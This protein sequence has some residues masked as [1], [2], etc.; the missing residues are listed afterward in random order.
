MT[1]LLGATLEPATR[2]SR[3]KEADRGLRDVAVDVAFA[4]ALAMLAVVALGPTFGG[5]AY[6]VI[7]AV[8]AVAGTGAALV[9]RRFL[10]NPI[11]AVPVAVVVFL[12][13]SGPALP[14]RSIAGIVPTPGSLQDLIRGLVHAWV[15]ALT[16]APPI[17]VHYGLG[18]IPY[19]GGFLGAVGGVSIAT[20]TK[21]TIAP[22]LPALLVL[23]LHIAIGTRDPQSLLLQGG[24]GA[25]LALGWG[26]VRSNRPRRDPAGVVYWPRIAQGVVML[27]AL[28]GL[29]VTLGP[30]APGFDA[31]QR[32]ILRDDVEPPFDPR[33]YPSP[34]VG[35]RRYLGD[36]GKKDVVFTVNGL[37]K[38]ASLRLATM[39]TYDGTVWAVGGP[40]SASSGRF[41][42]IGTNVVPVPSGTPGV[43]DVD[44]DGYQGVWVPTVGLT[45]STSFEGPRADALADSYRFNEVTRDGA[46][47]AIL[48]KGDRYHVDV[49]LQ[50][51]FQ[52]G[53]DR[54]AV[55][56]KPRDG[57]E[58]AALPA[59]PDEIPAG[60]KE[61]AIQLVQ[62][63][64]SD[65]DKAAQIE[66][67]FKK[68]FY[69][70]G[71]ANVE[72]YK[73]SAPGHSLLRMRRFLD[74]TK[75]LPQ[76]D[77]EQYAS[78]MALVARLNN[79]PARVVMG[80][81]L[82]DS[83]LWHTG[84]LDL[85]GEDADAW[86]EI[87]FEDVGWVRFDPTPPRNNFPKPQQ[88][89]TLVPRDLD[90]Q[91]EPE[92]DY[93]S[94]PDIDTKERAGADDKDT[95]DPRV[96]QG[97]GGIP[98]FVVAALTYVGAP[99]VGLAALAGAVVLAKSQRRKRR[100]TRGSPV[101]RAVG[102]WR[103]ALDTFRDHRIDVGAGPTRLQVAGTVPVEP[104]AG[105]TA[106]ASDID[107]LMF[108]AAEPSDDAVAQIWARLDEQRDAVRSPLSPKD[109][110]RGALSLS[111]FGRHR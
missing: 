30:H 22:A 57:A 39:D 89:E 60:I 50:P 71:G 88:T 41:D 44:V 87:K 6:L 52:R 33:S 84:P 10:P 25:L 77:E 61:R 24:G 85:H 96:R 95:T 99:A 18:V 32:H 34:L 80:F 12:L 43:V 58:L 108:S 98:R 53:A 7:G 27:V 104:W 76:G 63:A 3:T 54:S 105:S 110:L 111:S 19:V 101:D 86:V 11:L 91:P 59:L 90:V 40:T 8:G 100:R 97:G 67:T 94:P 102:A 14:D 69:S 81:T 82:H 92:Q 16:T 109:R 93:V 62:G 5:T 36:A 74:P 26:A 55:K 38:G 28:A 46:A 79:L 29:G 45:Q 1:G 72:A 31:G 107:R 20:R 47:P 42:R 70:N 49:R 73:R 48:T 103:E 51:L 68:G 9:A 83:G 17:G 4:V 78:A 66:A 35:I 56:N 2:P 75:A 65:Y 37:P 13:C 21:T 15:D 64:K 106:L 23:A